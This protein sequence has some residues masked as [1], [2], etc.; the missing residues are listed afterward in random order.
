MSNLKNIYIQNEQ[1]GFLK[2]T[3]KDF[4]REYSRKIFKI[5]KDV[6]KIYNHRQTIIYCGIHI[7]TIFRSTLFS[8]TQRRWNFSWDMGS[9]NISIWNLS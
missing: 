7:V 3:V 5:E 4:A 9:L 8:R 1:F 6:Q 2:V